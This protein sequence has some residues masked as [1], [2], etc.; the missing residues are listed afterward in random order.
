M[1]LT[2]NKSD[3]HSSNRAGGGAKMMT[4]IGALVGFI[5][6]IL[7]YL[8]QEYW[9]ADFDDAYFEIAALFFVATFAFSALMLARH[10]QIIKP[11]IG[12]LVIA[13]ALFVLDYNLISFGSARD[14]DINTFPLFFWVMLSRSLVLFLA[15]TLMRASLDGSFPP[16]YV[17]VFENGVS[18]PI[19]TAGAK[20]IAL[21]TLLLLFAWARLLK[22]FDVLFF[23]ELFQEQW[24]LFPFLGA[25][26]G[27]SISLM[28]GQ[29]AVISAIRFLLKL[30]SRIT[31]F[32]SALFT[33]T[34]AMVLITKGTSALF[35][36]DV[37]RPAVILIGLAMTG[38]LIFNGVYQDGQDKPPPLWLRIPTLITLIGF[39][40]YSSLAFMAL[41]ARIDD[42]GLTPIRITGLVI[43]GMA[44]LYSIVCL[45][46]LLSELRWRAQR[47]MVPV[48]PLNTVMASIWILALAGL[49]SPLI[50][51]WSISAQS[52]FAR[53]ASEKV[54]AEDF[55]YGYVRFELG[56]YGEEQ[57]RKMKELDSHPQIDIIRDEVDE[58]LSAPSYWEYK[59]PLT[60]DSE[61]EAADEPVSDL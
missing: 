37:E 44:A 47:W 7:I 18:I 32:V 31:I 58:V 52:Q 53:I 45:A 56:K 12:A 20:L 49:A 1:Q 35:E 60:D 39:P 23:H 48:G 34:L 27:L 9:I 50:N 10:N 55:D 25:I 19:I 4:L 16:R 36:A 38:M 54:D 26:A 30:L 2:L 15:L 14:N 24:F 33:I 42:Y 46:G 51:L 41:F 22:E 5:A 8:I 40:V 6:G 57:L 3:R 21:L 28:H 43:A 17:D 29:T 61:F 59:F 13:G 11:V